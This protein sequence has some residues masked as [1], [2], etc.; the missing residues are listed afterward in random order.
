[1]ELVELSR[2]K[3]GMSERES[4]ISL[5]QIIR[6]KTCTHEQRNLRKVTNLEIPQ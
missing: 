2:G 1:M 4:F 6:A 3:K 5:K